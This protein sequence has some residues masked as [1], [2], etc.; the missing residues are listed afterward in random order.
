MCL[1]SRLSGVILILSIMLSG[2]DVINVAAN[3]ARD[4]V[5]KSKVPGSKYNPTILTVKDFDDYI[6]MLRPD[7]QK[8][9]SDEIGTYFHR[10]SKNGNILESAFINK[11]YGDAST[12]LLSK[13]IGLMEP[14]FVFDDDLVIDP[15]WD[16]TN[17]QYKHLTNDLHLN[18]LPMS[19]TKKYFDL[20]KKYGNTAAG[21]DIY[22]AGYEREILGKIQPL[23][24]YIVVREVSAAHYASSQ[25]DVPYVGRK[26]YVDY[27]INAIQ[28]INGGGYL[29]FLPR[30]IYKDLHGGNQLRVSFC[31][32][33][34][35]E[36]RRLQLEA[37][38][39]PSFWEAYNN[40]SAFKG[41][42][43]NRSDREAAK[44]NNRISELNQHYNKLNKIEK[45]Y[46]KLSQRKKEMNA[47]IR[48][49]NNV[50]GPLGVTGYIKSESLK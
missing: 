11:D 18:I 8:I 4:I 24:D 46:E 26:Y 2:C 29:G 37:T 21:R 7:D 49:C 9:V 17:R 1:L 5:I 36:S 41:D 50:L 40:I 44:S 23:F 25:W 33:L 16:A 39:Q 38:A 13:K 32:I 48:F 14:V 47:E 10:F 20:V 28:S 43:N 12:N 42:V 6:N 31:R 15:D 35:I 34:D 30:D 27:Y 45:I 19:E 3:N 22:N